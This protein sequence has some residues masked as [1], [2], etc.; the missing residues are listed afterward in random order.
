MP[1]EPLLVLAAFLAAFGLFGV[2]VYRR[3]E[4]MR[5][6]Q[7][8]EP[9]G[10]WRRRIWLWLVFVFGQR[11]LFRFARPGIAHFFVFWGFLLLLPTIAQAILEGVF[12]GFVIPFLGTFGPLALVQDLVAVAVAIAV[13][14]ALCLRLIVK[15]ERYKGSH[16]A[17]GVVVLLFI[18]TIM[19][20]LPT[21]S[22]SRP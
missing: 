1:I 12:P 7:P 19:V 6:G 17:E 11:R 22:P 10:Q 9:I 5:L 18:L 3:V 21:G 2:R 16:Q 4:H 15:P 13:L 14:Y 20:S 8:A